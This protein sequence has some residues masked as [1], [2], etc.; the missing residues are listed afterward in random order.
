MVDVTNQERIVVSTNGDPA[1][2]YIMLPLDQVAAVETMLREN[3]I[4]YWVASQAISINN[5]PFTSII[6]LGRGTDPVRV[7]ALLDAA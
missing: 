3:G 2:P 1:F 7:Q 6:N 4:D 5:R